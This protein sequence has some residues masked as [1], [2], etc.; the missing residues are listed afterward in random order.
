MPEPPLI[1]I[2]DYISQINDVEK[3]RAIQ[4][5]AQMQIAVADQ[6]QD[7]QFVDWGFTKP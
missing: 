7:G 3:L 5:L 2:L 1:E 4:C 6:M